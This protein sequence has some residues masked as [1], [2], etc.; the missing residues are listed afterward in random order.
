MEGGIN[1]GRLVTFGEIMGRI[2]PEG[3]KK[4]RQALPGKL[5]FTFAGSEANVAVSFSLMGG[6]SRFVTALPAN[7]I[8]DACIGT[9]QNYGVDTSCIVQSE[10]GRFGFYFVETGANQRPS[11]VLYDREGTAISLTGPNEY[12]WARIFE[13]AEWF[14]VSGITP[15][16]S[17]PASEASLAAV[18]KAKEKG[19]TVSCDLNFRKKL[20]KWEPGTVGRDLARRVMNELLES[21]D[22]VIGNE[23]DASDVLDIQ[24][25]STDVEKGFLEVERYP[26]VAKQIISRFPQVKI[27]ATTLRES[28]S[29][30]HN[31]WGGMLYDAETGESH[32]APVVDGEYKPYRITGIIDRVGGGDAFSAGLVF[33]L[34]DEKLKAP[35][36]ALAY[37]VAA[38][39]LCQSIEGDFNI[40]SREE[41][42]ALMKGSVS[43]R[44]KR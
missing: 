43:G 3:F 30:T 32:F 40:S 13:G 35:E 1:G 15:A 18:K 25:G 41:V 21:V 6:R 38:G 5:E 17:K 42:E 28:I 2:E 19:L 4:F 16:I 11:T 7:S 29:A 12:E 37:A 8:G 24:A 36:T 33:A 20:W 22:V 26:E 23:E 10:N 44:V 14:H 9:L 31:N 34:M 27:V 39:C